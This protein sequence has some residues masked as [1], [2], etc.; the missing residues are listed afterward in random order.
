M[1]MMRTVEI[2]DP[3]VEESVGFDATFQRTSAA[4]DLYTF[5]G[6]CSR[7]IRL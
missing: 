1:M 4:S 7:K 6:G 3:E 2:T 5:R